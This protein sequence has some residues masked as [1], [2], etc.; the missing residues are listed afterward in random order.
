MTRVPINPAN[1][2][3]PRSPIMVNLQQY[4]RQAAS[5]MRSIEIGLGM[6]EA[7]RSRG[8]A[9]GGAC[10]APFMY[11]VYPVIVHGIFVS[12]LPCDK[13]TAQGYMEMNS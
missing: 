6:L 7:F 5:W 8:T 3:A 4:W 13:W 9:L 1:F 10:K 2:T 12:I 11:D